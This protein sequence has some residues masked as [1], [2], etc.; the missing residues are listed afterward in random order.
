MNNI[1]NP[2]NTQMNEV[3]N[4]FTD[5]FN[6]LL[7]AKSVEEALYGLIAYLHNGLTILNEVIS[8]FEDKN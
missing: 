4:I 3:L 1:K 8:R 2:V 6:F 7:E 5:E